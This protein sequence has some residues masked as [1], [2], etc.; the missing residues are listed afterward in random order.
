M[1]SMPRNTKEVKAELSKVK[2]KTVIVK[3]CTYAMPFWHYVGEAA[4]P[5]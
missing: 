5:H 2:R 4:T 1:Q 3:L